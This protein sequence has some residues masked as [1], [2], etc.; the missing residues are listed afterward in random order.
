MLA[1]GTTDLQ[2]MFL[3]T[4]CRFPPVCLRKKPPQQCFIAFNTV[5]VFSLSQDKSGV[6][7]K[8]GEGP[9]YLSCRP[10]NWTIF[11]HEAECPRPWR[12]RQKQRLFPPTLISHWSL[13]KWHSCWVVLELLG[14]CSHHHTKKMWFFF[15]IYLFLLKDNCFKNFV[16]FCQT[17]TWNSHRYT[18]VPS[19]L[20]L[21]PISLPI[22]SL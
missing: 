15:F 11:N 13:V 6:M 8:A 19:L 18:Y 14:P 22:S 17:S 2:H 20:N 10:V 7:P 4:E 12:L 3:F 5:W 1:W 9:W 16:I 21:P